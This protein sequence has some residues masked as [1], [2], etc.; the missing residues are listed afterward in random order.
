MESMT[1]QV[2]YV[3]AGGW[4]R[5]QIV[6]RAMSW[7]CFCGTPRDGDDNHGP[8]LSDLL[9][10]SLVLPHMWYLRRGGEVLDSPLVVVGRSPRSTL[11][12]KSRLWD[13][14][15]RLSPRVA[16]RRV[17]AG[18]SMSPEVTRRRLDAGRSTFPE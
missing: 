4:H 16:C 7:V 1:A 13:A 12:I 11:S 2:V 14:G 10:Q 8:R 6:M 18:R 9:L 5:W 3:F 17:D 15:R